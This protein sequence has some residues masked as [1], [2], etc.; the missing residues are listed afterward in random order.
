MLNVQHIKHLKSCVAQAKALFFVVSVSSFG[1]PGVPASQL[2]AL[3]R[4]NNGFGGGSR[5]RGALTFGPAGMK[6]LV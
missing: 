6:S 2:N 3:L 4:F 5:G 1:R